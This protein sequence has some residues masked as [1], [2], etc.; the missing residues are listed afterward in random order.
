VD[1]EGGCRGAR[2]ADLHVARPGPLST[3]ERSRHGSTFV[4]LSGPVP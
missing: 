2:R 1:G 4:V 3:P